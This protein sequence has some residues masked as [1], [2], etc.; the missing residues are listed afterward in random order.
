MFRLSS[1]GV[2]GH[3]ECVASLILAGVVQ[4]RLVDRGRAGKQG[5]GASG[6]LGLEG[7]CEVKRDQTFSVSQ[8]KVWGS[9]SS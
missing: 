4:I 6:V 2:R 8:H 3:W 7:K 9:S 5:N 1:L